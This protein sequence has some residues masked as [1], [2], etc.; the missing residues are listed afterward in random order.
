ML[1][2][3]RGTS[4]AAEAR[5]LA[6]LAAP[7]S[8]ASSA[9]A[10]APPLAAASPLAYLL[11]A[12][13]PA[14]VAPS[15]PRYALLA[16][17]A[18]AA[19]A[20]GGVL[21]TQCLLLAVGVGSAA[22][23]PA[24][25]ALNWVLKDGLGQVGGVAFAAAIGNRFD[26]DPKRWRLLSALALDCAS[27]LEIATPLWPALFVPVAAA[28]NC[29]KNV[30]WLSAS[31]SRAGI[32]Q[33]LAA[34]GNLADLTAK[35]GSQSIA[36]SALGTALGVALLAPAAAAAGAAGAPA[37]GGAG[38][39]AAFAL[40]SALHLAGVWASLR[41]VALPTLSAARMDLAA[42]EWV[43]GD[44]GGGGESGG[45]EARARARVRGPDAV[46]RLE[47]FL[48]WQ[49]NAPA[50]GVGDAAIV[51][52]GE[53]AGLRAPAH[54]C[55][56]CGTFDAAAP[57][58]YVL[59]FAGPGAGAGLGEGAGAALELRLHF[60]AEAG[61]RDVLT[62]YLHAMRLRALLGRAEGGGVAAAGGVGGA[63]SGGSSE[64]RE[65]ALL[66]ASRAW[67]LA[68]A[69]AAVAALDAA[70]WWVGSPLI[71]TAPQRRLSAHA[72]VR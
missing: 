55:A 48:P 34:R 44:G 72:L 18:T 58:R 17:C 6:Q 13:F 16:A 56:A 68:R 64:A 19:S 1:D 30:A 5:E 38:V 3:A 7:L 28:A 33:A 57:S 8:A 29:L 4:R 54:A 52:G 9:S 40:C 69:P 23:V 31:A 37:A 67:A 51:V 27:A 14:T 21:S 10:S 2:L 42:D 66:A 62:G 70:G 45:E 12:G 39:A 49:S 63:V 22:A 50:A 35:A 15:Y 47:R 24:A 43:R 41:S 11:P 65:D 26:A 60:A 32:H 25:A 36:A 20:A 71:D 59:G 61:W 46:A 53:L